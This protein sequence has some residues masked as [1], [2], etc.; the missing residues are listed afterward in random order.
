MVVFMIPFFCICFINKNRENE[1]DIKCVFVPSN[2]HDLSPTCLRV[3]KGFA[4][5][6]LLP[7]PHGR[8][9]FV[10]FLGRLFGEDFGTVVGDQH[11][12]LDAHAH[13]A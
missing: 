1:I 7:I 5:S 13:P 10:S 12:V 2:R 3:K 4:P 6:Q 11:V 8:L 9:D